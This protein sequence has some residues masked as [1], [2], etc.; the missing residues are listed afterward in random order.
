MELD[1]LI[2][3]QNAV[4]LRSVVRNGKS[5]RGRSIQALADHVQ[6]EPNDHAGEVGC[7]T[8][9]KQPEKSVSCAQHVP[10]DLPEGDRQRD[11]I[12]CQVEL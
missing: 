10:F 11:K 4:V 12:D 5:P 7:T 1:P 8:V 3:V 2:K 9:T 6:V